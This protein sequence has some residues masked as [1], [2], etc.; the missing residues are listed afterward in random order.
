VLD[1]QQT[2]QVWNANSTE[3]WGLR[4]DEVEGQHFLALGMGFPVEVLKEPIRAMLNGDQQES[5]HDVETVT[6]RGRAVSC[7]VRIMPLRT[8]ADELYG[9]ILLMAPDGQTMMS[10]A[11]EVS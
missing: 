11:R 6:R 1:R 7:R 4:P 2:V 8:Q 10:A 5:E 3:L 9:L